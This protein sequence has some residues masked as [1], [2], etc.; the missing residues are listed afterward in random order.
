VC[1][2]EAYPMSP[3]IAEAVLI[4]ETFLRAEAERCQVAAFRHGARVRA[5]VVF[6]PNDEAMAPQ[7]APSKGDLNGAVQL[8]ETGVG[9]NEQ[10]TPDRRLDVVEQDMQLM[11]RR[12]LGHRWPIVSQA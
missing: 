4:E 3:F 5:A 11:D 10:P 12:R 2:F 1:A 9:A 6:S 7:V 8:R